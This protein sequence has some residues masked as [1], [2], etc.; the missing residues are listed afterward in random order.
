MGRLREIRLLRPPACSRSRTTWAGGRT[1][2][3][4][5]WATLSTT[6]RWFRAAR[7]SR[8]AGRLR[9]IYHGAN[10]ARVPGSKPPLSRGRMRWGARIAGCAADREIQ[11]GLGIAE[12][13]RATPGCEGSL[14]SRFP[15]HE[16]GSLITIESSHRWLAWLWPAGI[17]APR[18]SRTYNP[19]VA[20]HVI[21]R[22]PMIASVL[23]RDGFRITLIMVGDRSRCVWTPT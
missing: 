16:S 19:L 4:V 22:T 14:R 11:L 1:T 13:D 3:P 7:A 8:V 2:S 12:A 9:S 6:R 23:V 15:L 18:R 20:R 5:W 10:L 21:S 17:G